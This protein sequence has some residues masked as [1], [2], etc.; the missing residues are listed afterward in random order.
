[1]ILSRKMVPNTKLTG[2]QKMFGILSHDFFFSFDNFNDF[3]CSLML[4]SISCSI[5]VLYTCIAPITK[6]NR[7]QLYGFGCPMM[8]LWWVLNVL[9]HCK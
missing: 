5:G 1:L 6:N 7:T 3:S 9:L 4:A 8:L 2:Q